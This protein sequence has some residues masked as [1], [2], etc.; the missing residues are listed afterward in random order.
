MITL[1]NTGQYCKQII[2]KIV[3]DQLRMGEIGIKKVV[4][5]I[6]LFLTR[7]SVVANPHIENH[8]LDFQKIL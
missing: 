7:I 2:R 1:H 5:R 6:V 4:K 3:T 8:N